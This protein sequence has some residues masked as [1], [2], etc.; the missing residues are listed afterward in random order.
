MYQKNKQAYRKRYLRLRAKYEA[1]ASVKF[2]RLFR[3]WNSKIELSGPRGFWRGQ[4]EASL[5]LE[6]MIRTYVEV[7][8][9][10]SIP[11]G[12]RV[13]KELDRA[14][15]AID[16]N[17]FTSD[18]NQAITRY[19]NKF[20]LTRVVSMR[21]QYI[22]HIVALISTDYNIALPDAELIKIIQGVVGHRNFYRW[23][24]ERIARTEA[25]AAASYGAV[26]AGESFGFITN[27]EWI[28]S[29]DPRTRR[30]P[31]GDYDHLE[32]DGVTVGQTE[33][34]EFNGGQD[35]IQYPGDPTG[36]ASNV[37]N[38]R[39]TIAVVPKRDANGRLIRK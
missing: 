26:K 36:Q 1:F 39:C 5:P 13:Q 24:A 21:R 32:M 23:Q 25:T 11:H 12:I 37:I 10:I 31:P 27:K 22:E 18:M 15:K 14:T 4:I 29:N 6:D 19:I 20:G 33:F 34:F 3:E 30:R 38:C 9:G 2:R 16:L 28:S 8:Q 35:R 17:K 7:Y